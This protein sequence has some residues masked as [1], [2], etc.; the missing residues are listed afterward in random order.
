MVRV[1][2]SVDARKWGR[3]CERMYR[4]WS[5]VGSLVGKVVFRYVTTED[6]VVSLEISSVKTLKS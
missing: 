2:R 4:R 6:S 3:M 5:G 1:S